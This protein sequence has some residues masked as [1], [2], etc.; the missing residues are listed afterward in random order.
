MILLFIAVFVIGLVLVFYECFTSRPFELRVTW[1]SGMA[2]PIAG[3][4]SLFHVEG[5]DG[6]G[7]V[8]P[9]VDPVSVVVDQ[10]TASINPDG[11]GGV[12]TPASVGPFTLTAA[13]GAFSFVVNGTVDPDQS[14]L[15]GIRVVFD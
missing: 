13:S 8:A 9:L 5:I 7:N 3:K 12:F 15:A 11:T 14:A 2:N 1:E 4:P 10:G 6:A